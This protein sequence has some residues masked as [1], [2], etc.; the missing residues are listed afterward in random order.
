[1]ARHKSLHG[2]ENGSLKKAGTFKKKRSGDHSNDKKVRLLV[3]SSKG[4]LDILSP[5]SDQMD[6]SPKIKDASRVDK[7]GGKTIKS[8]NSSISLTKSK[9][10]ATA[11]PQD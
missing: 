11:E 10:V 5:H 6:K 1:M 3:A 8:L 2:V 7:I 4:D 9:K